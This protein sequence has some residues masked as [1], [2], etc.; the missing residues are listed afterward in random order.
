MTLH[1]HKEV[2]Q[3][4]RAIHFVDISTTHISIALSVLGSFL[5]SP[6]SWVETFCMGANQNKMF[7]IRV[8]RGEEASHSLSQWGSVRQR[9]PF[10]VPKPFIMMVLP[11]CLNKDQRLF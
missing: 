5:T 2:L 8:I 1:Y 4:R 3:Q 6:P 7:S 9:R 10:T 11:L